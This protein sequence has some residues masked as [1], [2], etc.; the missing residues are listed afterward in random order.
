MNPHIT[1]I[2]NIVKQAK[3]EY[4][5]W[6]TSFMPDIAPPCKMCKHWNPQLTFWNGPTGS[7]PDGV[8]LCHADEM[9]QDFSCFC[10]REQE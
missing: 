2:E 9:H 10:A 5:H 6:V 3:I 1:D 8:Q 4:Q 7:T